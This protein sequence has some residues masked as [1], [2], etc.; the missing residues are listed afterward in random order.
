[1]LSYVKVI[2][3]VSGI[4]ISKGVAY[5]VLKDEN[6]QLQ[7]VCFTPE[8]FDFKNGDKVYVTGTPRYYVNG[9]KLNFNVS[10]IEQVG[11]GELYINFLLLKQKLELMGYFEQSNKKTIPKNI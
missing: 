10:K 5:F 6:A 3:E 9:G 1:M 2:G 8:K 4:S 11:L 7:C